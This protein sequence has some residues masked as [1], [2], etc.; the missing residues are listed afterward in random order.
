MFKTAGEMI[1]ERYGM[2]QVY[3]GYPSREGE[4]EE[5]I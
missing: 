2:G 1:A 3:L 5:F 4:E